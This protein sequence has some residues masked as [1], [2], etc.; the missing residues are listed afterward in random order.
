[1]SLKEKVAQA[2]LRFEG[3][4]EAAPVPGYIVSDLGLVR[5]LFGPT[6]GVNL[7]P[8]LT[9]SGYAQVKLSVD[10]GCRRVQRKFLIGRLV[11][12]TFIRSPRPEDTV[13]YLNWERLDNRAC[14]LCWETMPVKMHRRRASGRQ[15]YPRGGG[16]LRRVDDFTQKEIETLRIMR[17]VRG[18][19]LV[20][21][22]NTY[23]VSRDDMLVLLF[24]LDLAPPVDVNL[25]IRLDA[26]RRN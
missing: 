16:P 8:T 1:M 3:R 11:A 4:F 9:N 18:C 21:L 20:Y 15:Q 24:D 5:P 10:V 19:E 2:R 25:A 7:V 12:S 6:A 26:E 23:R 14:N 22:M 13:G 17:F